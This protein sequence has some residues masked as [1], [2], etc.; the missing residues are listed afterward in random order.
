MHPMV[1]TIVS[2]GHDAQDDGRAVV[3]APWSAARAHRD[4][5]RRLTDVTVELSFKYLNF[6]TQKRDLSKTSLSGRRFVLR[7]AKAD[8]ATKKKAF[9]LPIYL[10]LA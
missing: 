10:A 4:A 7:R 3:A 2:D 1:G 6:Q 9:A 5:T 8:A